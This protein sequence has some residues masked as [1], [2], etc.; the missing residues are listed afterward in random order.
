MRR[1][2][3]HHAVLG[4]CHECD[5]LRDQ[6]T[7]LSRYWFARLILGYGCAESVALSQ[8]ISI[9]T[10]RRDHRCAQRVWRHNTYRR[11]GA[12]GVVGWQRRGILNGQS[13]AANQASSLATR[14]ASRARWG[15]TGEPGSEAWRRREMEAGL[16][17][18]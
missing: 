5:S 4:R 15:G 17:H 1:S 3:C 14:R 6:I 13:P 7:R 11:L 2:R 12:M 8:Y 18:G 9:E 10:V 16:R